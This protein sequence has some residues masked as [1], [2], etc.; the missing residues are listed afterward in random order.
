MLHR[1]QTIFSTLQFSLKSCQTNY[2]AHNQDNVTL[3]VNHILIKDQ[4]LVYICS[5]H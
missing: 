3:V 2:N 4:Q 1:T 5:K